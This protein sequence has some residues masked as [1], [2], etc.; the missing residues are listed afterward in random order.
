MWMC[1]WMR[2]KARCVLSLGKCYISTSP[3]M[4]ISGYVLTE[5]TLKINKISYHISNV[6]F[7]SDWFIASLIRRKASLKSPFSWTSSDC[8]LCSEDYRCFIS[9]SRSSPC[10]RRISSLFRFVW[11][12]KSPLPSVGCSQSA[13]GAKL[14]AAPADPRLPAQWPGPV[15]HRGCF[16]VH[17]FVARWVSPVFISRCAYFFMALLPLIGTV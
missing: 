4:F 12:Q 8:S 7:S 13:C 9:C 1:V 17:F 15:E 16:W 14:W 3:Y 5:F 6:S 11:L 2:F 10:T